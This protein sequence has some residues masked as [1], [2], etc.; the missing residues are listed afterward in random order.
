MGYST[1]FSGTL[2]ISPKLDDSQKA[3]LKTFLGEDCRDHKEW[4]S[5]L[6]QWKSDRN[7]SYMDLEL[8]DAEDGIGW[9]GSEKTYDLVE[10]VD[11]L[12][13]LMR[14]QVPDFAL[15]G[16]L[17]AQGEDRSDTWILTADGNK[18]FREDIDVESKLVTCPN[19]QHN[20][21]A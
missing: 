6:P 11:L 12:I 10:K 16:K 21:I 17:Y 3:Y 8:N 13:N 7:L 5:S 2:K 9:D 4:F 19:C 1:D 15:H 14:L 20:F 18:V